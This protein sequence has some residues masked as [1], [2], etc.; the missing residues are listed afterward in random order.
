MRPVTRAARTDGFN[1]N[2]NFAHNFSRQ[3]RETFEKRLKEKLGSP[4]NKTIEKVSPKT[5][6]PATKVF[7][8]AAR[9]LL[10]AS[11]KI[12]SFANRDKASSVEIVST[13]KPS[14][15][16]ERFVELSRMME[17]VFRIARLQIEALKQHKEHAPAM[18]PDEALSFTNSILAQSF[19]AVQRA[20]RKDEA[21][22][23][24]VSRVIRSYLSRV[25]KAAER[26]KE[27]VMNTEHRR[28]PEM[29]WVPE[30]S[31]SYEVDF[32][33]PGL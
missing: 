28:T 5:E 19:M 21:P 18:S 29:P 12:Q 33:G 3:F 32:A 27:R 22:K 11:N 24:P 17:E 2:S 23:I 15:Y 16:E 1:L 10:E 30:A 31:E 13:V 7:E 26:V 4:V 6:K 25:S 20:R 14:V 9:S 8:D